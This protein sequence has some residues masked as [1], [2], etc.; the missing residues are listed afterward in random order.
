MK[1]T[2]AVLAL[3]AGVGPLAAQ[4]PA[5]TCLYVRLGGVYAIALVVDEYGKMV[6]LATMEDLLEELFGEIADEKEV[7]A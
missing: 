3:L 5:D 4:Q 7:R 2:L 6:G 1:S